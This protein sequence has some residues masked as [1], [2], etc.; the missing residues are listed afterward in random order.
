[1]LPGDD[2]PERVVFEALQSLNW[3]GIEKRTGR[4]YGSVVDAC[5]KVMA[6]G[7]HHDWVSQAASAL[8]LGPD[9]LWQAMCA[10]WA[11]E[12]LDEDEA[13]RVAQT[14][15]DTLMGI[16]TVATSERPAVRP[17]RKS[18]D[19]SEPLRQSE[20]FPSAAGG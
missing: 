18:P 10:E 8:A 17:T 16:S 14:V 4:G 15:G 1:M 20:L 5:E 7:D 11:T 12:C 19:S 6:L 2:A 3:V 9:T 13:N